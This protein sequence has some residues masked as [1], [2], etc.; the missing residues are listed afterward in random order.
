MYN[1]FKSTRKKET[2]TTLSLGE[3]KEKNGNQK[4]TCYTRNFHYGATLL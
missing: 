4:E 2:E 1:E 3:H